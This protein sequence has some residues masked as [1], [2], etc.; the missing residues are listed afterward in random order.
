MNW[1]QVQGQWKQLKGKAVAHW[2]ELT[3]DDVDKVNGDRAQLEGMIQKKY[4]KTKEAAK[5]EVDQWIAK[6]S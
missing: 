2:G 5:E 6:H 1:D 4:G 3:D